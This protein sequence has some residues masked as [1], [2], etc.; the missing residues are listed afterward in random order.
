LCDNIRITGRACASNG[1]A[2]FVL[3]E[4]IM[5]SKLRHHTQVIVLLPA[6]VHTGLIGHED[7]N[8]FLEGAR[9]GIAREGRIAALERLGDAPNEEAMFQ[10]S[11]DA[12]SSGAI[13]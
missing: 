10:I 3:E 13:E 1:A 2:L 9:R 6:M 12:A 8:R 4:A 5:A 7:R 11:I